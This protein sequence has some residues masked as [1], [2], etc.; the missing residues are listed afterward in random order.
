MAGRN[1]SP[2]YVRMPGR[3]EVGTVIY[4]GREMGTSVNVRVREVWIQSTGEVCF[5][6]VGRL[7]PCDESGNPLS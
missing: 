3:E 7:T 2:M 1:S 5:Y 4:G 6:E